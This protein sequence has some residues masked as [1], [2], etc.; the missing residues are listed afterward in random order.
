MLSHVQSGQI[1]SHPQATVKTVNPSVSTENLRKN[2]DFCFIKFDIQQRANAVLVLWGADETEETC[3]FGGQIKQLI[4]SLAGDDSDRSVRFALALE[5]TFNHIDDIG[6]QED[7]RHQLYATMN[8]VGRDYE[9]TATEVRAI[10]GES[11]KACEDPLIKQDIGSVNSTNV[12]ESPSLPYVPL[13]ASME[14]LLTE[15]QPTQADEIPKKQ[16]GS[17]SASHKKPVKHSR[18]PL[19][20]LEKESSLSE[21]EDQ[22]DIPQKKN[23]RLSTVASGV[24]K[25]FSTVNDRLSSEFKKMRSSIG[26]AVVSGE[27]PN[28]VASEGG[29]GIGGAVKSRLSSMAS[30]MKHAVSVAHDRLSVAGEKMMTSVSAAAESR[31]HKVSAWISRGADTAKKAMTSV[32]TTLAS[33]INEVRIPTGEEFPN[34]LNGKSLARAKSS[35]GRIAETAVETAKASATKVGKSLSKAADAIGEAAKTNGRKMATAA[36]VVAHGIAHG[37]KAAAAYVPKAA[38]WISNRWSGLRGFERV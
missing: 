13:P 11:L 5:F 37:A 34:A 16:L 4:S 32:R 6:L 35:A 19:V 22:V 12:S 7:R 14:S 31:R 26:Q 15:T 18:E 38:A 9:T 36:R 1:S 29:T 30:G 17:P 21:I 33:A 8:S 20:Q 25:A 10:V 27:S 2:L 24:K 28:V 23:F 3:S